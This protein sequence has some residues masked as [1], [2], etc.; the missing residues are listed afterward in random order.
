MK[1]PLFII[2]ISSLIMLSV[3]CT[4]LTYRSGDSKATY[5]DLRN[6]FFQRA[7]SVTYSPSNGAFTVSTGQLDAITAEKMKTI[8]ETAAQSAIKELK[9]GL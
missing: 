6:P 9:S 5:T 7:A 4:R 2:Q 8:A 1:N 3:G